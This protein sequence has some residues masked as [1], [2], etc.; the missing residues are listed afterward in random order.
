M[1]LKKPTAVVEPSVPDGLSFDPKEPLDLRLWRARKALKA[2]TLWAAFEANDR[3]GSFEAFSIHKLARECETALLDA[4]ILAEFNLV[5]WQKNGNVTVF[6]GELELRAVGLLMTEEAINVKAVGEAIDSYDKGIGKALSMARKHAFIQA[7]NLSIGKDIEAEKTVKAD[8]VQMKSDPP[9]A[10]V[11]SPG[12]VPEFY[13]LIGTDGRSGWNYGDR[14]SFRAAVI[15]SLDTLNDVSAIEVFRA[16]NM[17]MLQRY[18]KEA[19]A[20]EGHALMRAIQSK[21]DVLTK[22]IA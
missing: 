21:I 5:K 20:N 22:G 9:I 12:A 2:S 1:S 11:A 6:E 3:D 15:G 4:G 8:P 18:W 16:N 13:R 10:P 19:G 7:L 14:E 17:A